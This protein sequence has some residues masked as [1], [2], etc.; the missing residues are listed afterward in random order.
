MEVEAALVQLL[1]EVVGSA[2]ERVVGLPQGLAVVGNNEVELVT[3]QKLVQPAGD[4]RAEV[5]P[6]GCKKES[7]YR[8]TEVDMRVHGN[9]VF[10]HTSCLLRTVL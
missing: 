3:A 8:N 1:E 2:V 9:G 7:Y 4:S 10:A 5:R 6:G